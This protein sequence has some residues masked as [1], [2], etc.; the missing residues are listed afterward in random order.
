LAV[1]SFTNPHDICMF[2]MFAQHDPRVE[3][4]IDADVPSGDPQDDN[5]LFTWEDSG[6]TFKQTFLEDLDLSNKPT[7]QKSYRNTFHIWMQPIDDNPAYRQYY[8]QLHKNVDQE[9]M[10]VFNALQNSRYKDNTIVV[11]ASDHG[12]LLGAHG[13]MHQK[14][15]QAYEETV[16][17]PLIIWSPQ[18]F[19]GPGQVEAL[20]SHADIMPTLLGL[21]G[22]D[23]GPIREQL[24]VL[25]SDAVPFV[26]RDLSPL[27]LGQ[28]DP[29][30]VN[31]P[32]YFMTDDDVSRGLNID[33]RMRF[34][35][36][37][38]PVDEPNS[39]ETVI[40]HLED[41]HL[42]KYSR[43]FDN[44]QDWSSPGNPNDPEEKGVQDVLRVQAGPN[45][46]PDSMTTEVPFN[47]TVK[48]TPRPDEFEMYDLDA[49]PLELKNLY[50]DADYSAKQSA[51]AQLLEQQRALKR[52]RPVSGAVPGQ[53][54]S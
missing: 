16:R 14:F 2:G 34:G 33:R 5:F 40:A 38:N 9:M 36:D 17:V 1:C 13:D 47:L 4:K 50:G 12:D 25:H 27:I 24:A 22:I 54:V 26:G 10:K 7:A 20:T 8:Y 44:P 53:P 31:D 18:L 11:F 45:P 52:L 30:S 3:F 21:A 43:Y 6:Q 23:P 37:Y 46:P 41:G 15:Y 51:L 28:V 35:A 19:A 32:V 42:W 29:A 39:I 48:A 49:D